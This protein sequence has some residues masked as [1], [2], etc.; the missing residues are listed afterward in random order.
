MLNWGARGLHPRDG[1][2]FACSVNIV[3]G[4]GVVVPTKILVVSDTH[5]IL[6][7]C[8]AFIL[9]LLRGCNGAIVLELEDQGMYA[10]MQMKSRAFN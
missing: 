9:C 6:C 7:D 10:N 1:T 3:P 5:D 2:K 8:W 4:L